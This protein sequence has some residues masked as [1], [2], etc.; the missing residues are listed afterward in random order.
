MIVNP[1]GETAF[2]PYTPLEEEILFRNEMNDADELE[3]AFQRKNPEIS[4]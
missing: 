3:K 4:E 1:E 2:A